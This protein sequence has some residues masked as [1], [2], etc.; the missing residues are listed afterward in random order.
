[1][2]RG[3]LKLIEW[4]NENSGFLSLLMAGMTAILSLRIAKMPYKKA[5]SGT[6]WINQRET[7][8]WNGYACIT[9]VGRTPVFI[10]SVLVTNRW[11][12]TIGSFYKKGTETCVPLEPGESIKVEG[13]FEHKIFDKHNMNLNGHV[14]LKV[15]EIDG[16]KH[17]ISKGFG[18]G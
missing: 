5:I 8:I 1:M 6:L 12:K 10:K 18:V 15:V 13:M 7:N 11:R 16:K 2:E 3:R 17:Y 9:N 4:C 14:K